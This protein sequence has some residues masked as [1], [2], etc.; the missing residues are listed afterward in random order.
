MHRCRG[1]SSPFRPLGT[2]S[3]SAAEGRALSAVLCACAVRPVKL[4][5]LH[6]LPTRKP[7]SL[8][9]QRAAVARERSNKRTPQCL[10]ACACVWHCCTGRHGR[11][12]FARGDAEQP[13]PE[14]FREGARYELRRGCTSSTA[15]HARACA[16]EHHAQPLRHLVFNTMDADKGNLFATVAHNQVSAALQTVAATEEL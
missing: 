13:P 15:S 16:Q 11:P 8:E 7:C 4:S 9:R 5:H 14:D 1:A 2:V 3:T 6:P 10:S 12:A